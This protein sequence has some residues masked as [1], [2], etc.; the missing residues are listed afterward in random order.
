MVKAKKFNYHWPKWLG[1]EIDNYIEKGLSSTKII[2]L[3]L[4][5][6]NI[7]VR[8]GGIG[9][10]IRKFKM[11]KE[12]KP[13]KKVTKNKKEGSNH[14][15]SISTENSSSIYSESNQSSDF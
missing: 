9:K 2:H 5:K 3:I 14:T 13:K 7:A 1:K 8:A 12:E 11:A 10:R 6:Y 4:N 15:L